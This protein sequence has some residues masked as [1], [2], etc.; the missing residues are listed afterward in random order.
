LPDRWR[1]RGARI[2][3]PEIQPPE[4]R[5]RLSG[6]SV[7]IND[8]YTNDHDSARIATTSQSGALA[9]DT[10]PNGSALTAIV[11]WRLTLDLGRPRSEVASGA[12]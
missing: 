1:G 7:A 2:Y 5:L 3:W 12:C 10:D 4:D 8:F 9:D 11:W 6:N